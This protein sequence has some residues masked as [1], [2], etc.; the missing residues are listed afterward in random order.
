M[1]YNINFHLQPSFLHYFRKGHPTPLP[2]P[3]AAL[4]PARKEVNHG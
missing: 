3:V 2:F 4:A 1:Q